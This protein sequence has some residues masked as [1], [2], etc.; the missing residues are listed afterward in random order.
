MTKQA[1]ALQIIIQWH[2]KKASASARRPSSYRRLYL[3][4]TAPLQR[5]CPSLHLRYVRFREFVLHAMFPFR[6][7]QL[8]ATLLASIMTRKRSTP[9]RKGLVL[10]DSQLTVNRTLRPVPVNDRKSPECRVPE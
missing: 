1:G 5:F 8:I 2:I 3:H 10:P 7:F 4:L 6:Q 9:P